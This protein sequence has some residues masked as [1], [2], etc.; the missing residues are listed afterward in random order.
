MFTHDLPFDPTYGYTEAQMRRILPPE[1]AAD[2]EAF[3]RQMYQRSLNVPTRTVFSDYSGP[4]RNDAIVRLIDFDAMGLGGKSS[5]RLGG[6]LIEPKDVTP[7]R[8]EVVGHGYG[9]REAPELSGANE[10]VVRLQ[11]CKRGFHRSIQPDLPVNDSSRHVVSGIESKETYVHLGNAADLWAGVK[12]LAELYPSL[13]DKLDYAGGSFG[14]GI[15]ALAMPWDQRVRRVFL[16][17]PSFGN[18]PLRLTMR[19][20]GSGEA[21]RQLHHNGRDLMPVLQYFDAA[22]AA[23]FM[24]KPTLVGCARFDPAVPPPG[25]FSVY[26]AIPCTKKLVS[27]AGGHWEYP[28]LAREVAVLHRQVRQWFEAP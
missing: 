5:V 16:D 13:A 27:R 19:C 25:Q 14:G 17:V 12:V 28:Q 21:I 1:P 22:V 4:V 9:G 20:N 8:L 24:D 6:W 7:Q 18:H 15:G 2:F 26:N 3:W 10:P 11:L 23:R